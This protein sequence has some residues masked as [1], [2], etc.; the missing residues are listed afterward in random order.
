MARDHAAEYGSEVCESIADIGTTCDCIF[1]S[2]PTSKEVMEVCSKLVRI[3]K[4][5]T[6]VVDCTSGEPGKT[7]EIADLLSSRGPVAAR[8][9]TVP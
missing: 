7:R 4:P 6:I 3:M 2:L 1:L 8:T 5:N 9:W